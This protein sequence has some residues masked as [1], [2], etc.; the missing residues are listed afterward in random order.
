V[1]ATSHAA[2]LF[3][4]VHIADYRLASDTLRRMV[5]LTLRQM[6]G[7]GQTQRLRHTTTVI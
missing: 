5:E 4:T 2:L 6:E 3:A 1:Q 7:Y